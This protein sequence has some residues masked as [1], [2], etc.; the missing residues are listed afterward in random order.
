MS[1]N[2]CTKS[3][4]GSYNLTGGSNITRSRIIIYV[5]CFNLY[6][7]IQ[8]F[9]NKSQHTYTKNCLHYECDASPL[10]WSNVQEM[11]SCYVGSNSDTLHTK[12]FTAPPIHKDLDTQNRHKIF[13][14]IQKHFGCKIIEKGFLFLC[15]CLWHPAK[16]KFAKKTYL[17]F[18]KNLHI[19][20]IEIFNFFYLLFYFP[21]SCNCNAFI[22]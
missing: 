8:K 11:V 15:K 12:L 19:R 10:K 17:V 5:D 14:T 2:K 4:A 22:F 7:H 6:H 21:V 1:H 3:L 13:R 16:V 18:C 9:C 20:N